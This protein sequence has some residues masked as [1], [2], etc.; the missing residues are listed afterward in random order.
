MQRNDYSYSAC[1]AGTIET[2]VHSIRKSLCLRCAFNEILKCFCK[3]ISHPA[4]KLRYEI[5]KCS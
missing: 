1:V 2:N 4:S 5:W 3:D